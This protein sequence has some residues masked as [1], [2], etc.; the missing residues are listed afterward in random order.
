MTSRN[1]ST[2]SWKVTRRQPLVQPPERRPMLMQMPLI[3]AFALAAAAE[4]NPA[5]NPSDRPKDVPATREEVKDALNQLR[6][7]KPRLPLPPP[8]AEEQQAARE[9]AAASGGGA[10]GLG[11]GLVN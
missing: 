5:D 8:T 4:D 7:R 9:R 6:H 11:T 3:V 10:G 1:E 2:S